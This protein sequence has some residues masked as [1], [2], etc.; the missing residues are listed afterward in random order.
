MYLQSIILEP[1]HERNTPYG[2]M[3][4]AVC[5]VWVVARER[6]MTTAKNETS[7]NLPRQYCTV[8]VFSTT[9]KN[10]CIYSV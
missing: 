2:I 9:I 8:I 6:D 4:A 7:L 3:N 5:G 10:V 1:V